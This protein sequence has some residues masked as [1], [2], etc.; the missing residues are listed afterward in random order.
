MGEKTILVTGATAGIG[1]VT[2]LE[3]ARDKFTVVLV[4]RNAEKC[5]HVVSEIKSATGNEN[6][7]AIVGD[8]SLMAGV[9]AVADEFKRRHDRLD[10]LVNNAGAIFASRTV[11]AEG[12]ESTWALN[13]LSYFLLTRQLLDVLKASAPARIVNVASDAHT[14]AKINFDDVQFARG[15]TA[16]KAYGQS[17]L[18]NIMFTYEL[19]RRLNGLGITANALH[20]GAVATNFG[21]N[22][23]GLVGKGIGLVMRVIG[24]TPAQGAETSIYLA[25]APG[26]DGI[27]GKYW[28]KRVSKASSMQSNIESDQ[29]RLWNLSEEMLAT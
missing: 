22:N 28:V 17:K 13:H 2:A 6:V 5:D 24:I 7:S 19:A 4:G 12:I 15:Y 9:H 25:S 18:A 10:V 14:G 3:L 23:S 16:W 27:S 1:R 21:K 20:P 8:L 29:R 26:L 11:T